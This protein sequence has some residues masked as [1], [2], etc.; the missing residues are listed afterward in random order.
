[1]NSTKSSVPPS[2]ALPPIPSSPTPSSILLPKDSNLPSTSS[3][4]TSTV[5]SSSRHTF[6]LSILRSNSTVT[7]STVSTR[8]RRTK[9]SDALARLEGRSSQWYSKGRES[10][11]RARPSQKKPYGDFMSMSDDS[12]AEDENDDSFIDIGLEFDVGSTRVHEQRST[13]FRLTS[14]TKRRSSKLLPSLST[15]LHS[16]I[17]LADQDARVRTETHTGK[18]RS[19]R[20]MSFIEI[21]SL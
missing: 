5:A 8:H 19:W 6:P 18:R 11:L 14:A 13:T 1:M 15:P 4:N 2:A 9:R 17:D 16:F 12:D 7:S 21:S 20:G 3:K 10:W